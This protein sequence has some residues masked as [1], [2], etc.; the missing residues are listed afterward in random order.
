MPQLESRMD[1]VKW[2]VGEYLIAAARYSEAV[3]DDEDAQPS[4]EIIANLRSW[5]DNLASS[6][7]KLVLRIDGDY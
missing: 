5:A 4:A 1:E 2:A 6:A 3:G 7:N